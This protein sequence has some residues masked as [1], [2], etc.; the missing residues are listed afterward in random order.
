MIGKSIDTIAAFSAVLV[1]SILRHPLSSFENSHRGDRH[2]SHS[3]RHTQ[4]PVPATIGTHFSSLNGSTYFY[5]IFLNR[6][7]FSTRG[8]VSMKADNCPNERDL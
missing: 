3:S 5:F 1:I 2:L 8:S 4:V 6:T 7:D